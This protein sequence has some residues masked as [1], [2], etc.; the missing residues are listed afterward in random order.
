MR[1]V[2]F[3]SQQQTSQK[4]R[5]VRLEGVRQLLD[6]G[7]DRKGTSIV[8]E[9]YLVGASPRRLSMLAMDQLPSWLQ[10]ILLPKFVPSGRR[11]G[12]SIIP[13]C[14]DLSNSSR[15]DH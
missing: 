4:G 1:Q 15:M 8:D 7:K 3:A 5:R 14:L 9:V 13:T 2:F 6:R 12:A 10:S 11:E